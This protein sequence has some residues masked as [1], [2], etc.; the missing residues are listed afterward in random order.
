MDAPGGRFHSQV[1]R[2][3]RA[4][5][6][7]ACLHIQREKRVHRVPEVLT[8]H[9]ERRIS[10]PGGQVFDHRGFEILDTADDVGVGTKFSWSMVQASNPYCAKVFISE[11]SPRLGAVRSK[12]GREPLTKDVQLHRLFCPILAA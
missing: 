10:I 6:S 8:V 12:L 11:Y 9:T 3:S 2:G 5:L 4:R 7:S 1:T